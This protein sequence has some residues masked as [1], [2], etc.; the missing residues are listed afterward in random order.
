[1]SDFAE[2]HAAIHLAHKYQCPDVET[3]ALS[4]LKRYYTSHFAEYVR[5]ST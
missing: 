1:M 5:Y 4:V 2:L 3:R